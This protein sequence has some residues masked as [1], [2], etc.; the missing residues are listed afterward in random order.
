VILVF[1]TMGGNLWGALDFADLILKSGNRSLAVIE[2]EANSAAV[3]IFL[4]CSERVMAD[5]A[6]I[7]VHALSV[8]AERDGIPTKPSEDDPIVKAKRIE[9]EERL[10][11]FIV[12]R[13]NI[14]R[15]EV[16]SFIGG[17]SRLFNAHEALEV[18]LV[19]QVARANQIMQRTISELQDQVELPFKG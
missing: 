7:L 10:A 6:Y 4:A 19:T 9:L 15:E 8:K 5:D 3:P 11:D 13:T 2:T 14:S 16:A 1:D 12:T 17:K 18:G